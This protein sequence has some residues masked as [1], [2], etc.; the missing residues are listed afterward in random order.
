MIRW[1]APIWSCV[2]LNIDGA[3]KGYGYAGTSGLL[4]DFNGNYLM[5]LT[6]NLRMCSILS[7]DLWG[8][9]HGLRI[10]WDHGF[11]RL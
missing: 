8:L 4:R 11:R 1:K 9:L 2:S 6:V 5:G 3:K 7:T 10:A